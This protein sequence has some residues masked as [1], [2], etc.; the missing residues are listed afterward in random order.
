MCSSNHDCWLYTT[1][2]PRM[3]CLV[4]SAAACCRLPRAAAFSAATRSH[5]Q[6]QAKVEA[7]RSAHCGTCPSSG[8]GK[9]SEGGTFSNELLTR[10]GFRTG[11]SFFLFSFSATLQIEPMFDPSA[12]AHVRARPIHCDALHVL[13]RIPEA[14]TCNRR[15]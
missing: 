6:D 8:M 2:L 7:S 13:E 15:L 4:R 9:G 1:F 12:I 5:A 14:S 3:S 10:L 11:C